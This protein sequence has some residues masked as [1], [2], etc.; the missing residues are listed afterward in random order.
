MHF[1]NKIW[2]LIYL[3]LS[4][5][6]K[7]LNWYN[8]IMPKKQSIVLISLFC[9]AFLGLTACAKE[10]ATTIQSTDTIYLE[11]YQTRT[12][13]PTQQIIPTQAQPTTPP[14]PTPTPYQYSIQGGDTLLGIAY[15]FG[16]TLDEL[17]IANPQINPALLIIGQIV[18]IPNADNSTNTPLN[19]TTEIIPLDIAQPLCYPTTSDGLW[20]LVD[21]QNN[22]ASLAENI[23]VTFYLYNQN[24][25]LLDSHLGA[26]P[27]NILSPQQRIPASYHFLKA[28]AGFSYAQTVLTSAI[29]AQ[30]SA[31][32]YISTQII[33]KEVQLSASKTSATITGILQH[34][35][36]PS[37]YS[38]VIAVA[39]DS[40]NQPIGIRLWESTTLSQEMPF[41][42]AVYSLSGAIEKVEILTETR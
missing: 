18:T 38:W 37:T 26:P 31:N 29:Q 32:R 14:L 24:G 13:R 41:T 10:S 6:T 7:S 36:I 30:S 35:N 22:T 8:H 3:F 19:Y 17:L 2:I 5:Q 40:N 27:S 21:I 39:Y 12:P 23:S 9:I 42:L 16:I 4:K 33:Q 34:Q 20:C 11:S 1:H 25:G 28:P 15:R